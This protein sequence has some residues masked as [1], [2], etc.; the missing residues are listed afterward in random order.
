MINFKNAE[1]EYG[2]SNAK[3]REA[4][5]RFLLAK[6]RATMRRYGKPDMSD[7]EVLGHLYGDY[8]SITCFG[9]NGATIEETFGLTDTFIR[10]AIIPYC[11]DVCEE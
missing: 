3:Y 8:D 11:N 4:V 9:A 7:N 5:E 1:K 10:N 2:V 6:E